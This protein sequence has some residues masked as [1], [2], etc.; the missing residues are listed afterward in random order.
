MEI[1]AEVKDNEAL[2]ALKASTRERV[3][4][5]VNCK[6]YSYASNNS[7]EDQRKQLSAP[8]LNL[9]ETASLTDEPSHHKKTKK[10]NF[11][12][13]MDTSCAKDGICTTILGKRKDVI[14]LLDEDDSKL[15]IP[16]HGIP[17]L[18]LKHQVAENVAVEKS[19]VPISKAASDTK[20]ETLACESSNLVGPLGTGTGG[21]NDNTNKYLAVSIDEDVA[22]LRD[23]VTQIEPVLNIRKESTFPSS[24]CNPGN[25]FML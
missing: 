3:S 5:D 20:K 14:S 22:L 8:M 4:D 6:S 19:T 7:S 2:R 9:E 16:M 24:L 12:N 21:D 18:D 25:L 13:D 10:F 15:S 23:S 11:S 1:A 17:N